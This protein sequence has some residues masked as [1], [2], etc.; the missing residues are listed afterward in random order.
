MNW[1]GFW[2]G[3][4]SAQSF[5]CSFGHHSNALDTA[6]LL[7]A[8]WNPIGFARQ[9]SNSRQ[10]QPAERRQQAGKKRRCTQ[11]KNSLRTPY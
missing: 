11:W 10:W 9:L 3:F 8:T 4:C 6:K 2:L 7:S 5:Q 1:L